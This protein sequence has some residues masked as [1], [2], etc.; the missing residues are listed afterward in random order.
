MEEF[1]KEKSDLADGNVAMKSRRLFLYCVNSNGQV[2]LLEWSV[3][4][5]EMRENQKTVPEV[6]V[7]TL[8]SE[9]LLTPTFLLPGLTL[10]DE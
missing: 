6:Q 8:E 2:N 1:A 5:R 3:I 10:K 9:R 7:L 4:G